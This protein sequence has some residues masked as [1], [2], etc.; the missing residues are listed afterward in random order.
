MHLAT[1]SPPT[2]LTGLTELEIVYSDGS[3]HE[4]PSNGN[5]REINK[6]GDA[7]RFI[8]LSAD[9]EKVLHWREVLG[10]AIA[11]EHNMSDPLLHVLKEL[12]EGYALFIKIT[13]P[14]HSPKRKDTCLFG[15]FIRLKNLCAIRLNS[16]SCK[17]CP[18]IRMFRSPNEFRRHAIWLYNGGNGHCKCGCS[19]KQLWPRNLGC[20]SSVRN[21]PTF[22]KDSIA[23]LQVSPALHFLVAFKR[24]HHLQM[25]MSPQIFGPGEIVWVM[26]PAP[27]RRGEDIPGAIDTWPGIVASYGT[28]NCRI[29]LLPGTVVETFSTIAILPWSSIPYS[30]DIVDS[31]LRSFSSPSPSITRSYN[32]TSSSCS[33]NEGIMALSLAC[34]AAEMIVRHAGHFIVDSEGTMSSDLD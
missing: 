24:K 13:G 16:N 15:K 20:V 18:S 14:V 28:E 12:P 33:W 10:E 23:L 30:R 17:G 7:V 21:V 26:L 9:H 31:Y 2:L 11:V 3:V 19:N 29:Q 22:T 25:S 34:N 1:A 8:K 27:I 32:P 6:S 5:F 4:W